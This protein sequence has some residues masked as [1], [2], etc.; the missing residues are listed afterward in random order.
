M[1][2]LDRSLK[3]ASVSFARAEERISVLVDSMEEVK[4][5]GSADMFH[6]I[7][8]SRK[9]ISLMEGL[10]GVYRRIHEMVEEESWFASGEAWDLL[11]FFN[12][13]EQGVNENQYFKAIEGQF[14]NAGISIEE[15]A[16]YFNSGIPFGA[17]IDASSRIEIAEWSRKIEISQEDYVDLR[18]AEIADLPPFVS[19]LSSLVK[20]Y[21]SQDFYLAGREAHFGM[22]E[23]GIFP[24]AHWN[25]MYS[26]Q[27][28]PKCRKAVEDVTWD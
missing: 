7:H 23:L 21:I 14:E 24:Y 18:L 13:D 19:Q 1:S 12:S 17:Y 27:D 9:V 20:D 15:L 6:W 11:Y 5:N 28:F 26:W 25:K 22:R 3:K 2:Y 16:E 10:S 4:I 8:V